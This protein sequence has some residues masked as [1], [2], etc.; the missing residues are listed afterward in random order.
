MGGHDARE[1]RREDPEHHQPEAHHADG[2][3][4]EFAVKAEPALEIDRGREDH[5][6]R[7]P[8]R[9]QARRHAAD[10]ARASS[11]GITMPPTM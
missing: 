4:E 2:A 3:V 7:D 5:D 11:V 6:Q 8:D 9:R 1:G 10:D